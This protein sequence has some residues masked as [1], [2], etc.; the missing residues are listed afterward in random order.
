M[1]MVYA[2]ATSFVVSAS[3]PS[4]IYQTIHDETFE[5][6]QGALHAETVYWS[7]HAESGVSTVNVIDGNKSLNYVFDAS[8]GTFVTLGGTSVNAIVLKD[9]LYRVS[10]ELKGDGV[11][12]FSVKIEQS[13][14]WDAYHSF[15][16]NPKTGNR[17]DDDGL[18]INLS[19]DESLS[20][21][22][23]T[24]VSSLSFVFKAR[25]THP[26]YIIFD[27]KVS[28]SDPL[29]VIDNVKIE[30]YT[31]SLDFKTTVVDHF[32]NASGEIHLNSVFFLN[33]DEGTTGSFEDT[34]GIAIEN[35]SL[36]FGIQK[37]GWDIL[38][39]TQGS[40][41]SIEGGHTY[42]VSFDL[43][44][45][46][47]SHFVVKAKKIADD[48]NIYEMYVN[49]QGQRLP[50]SIPITNV[51]T[52]TVSDSIIHVSF[53]FS[54]LISDGIYLFFEA[55]SQ[56]VGGIVAI[57]HFVVREEIVNLEQHSY[58]IFHE[59]TFEGVPSETDPLVHFGLT[60]GSTAKPYALTESTALRG[61][62]SLVYDEL[63]RFQWNELVKTD[64]VALR[65]NA[66]KFHMKAVFDGIL[67]VKMSLTDAHG[68]IIHEL[69]FNAVTLKRTQT[70]GKAY[71][72]QGLLIENRGTL[73]I[74]Y[75]F[76]ELEDDLDHVWTLSVYP[77]VSDARVIIDDITFLVRKDA[78]LIDETLPAIPGLPEN[79]SDPIPTGKD[80]AYMIGS[81][82][83]GSST[84][85]LVVISSVSVMS[86]A[87]GVA[88]VWL[89]IKKVTIIAKKA[90]FASLIGLASLGL[91]FGTFFGCAKFDQSVEDVLD[92]A[93]PNISNYQYVYPEKL[94]GNLNN[95]GMGWVTLEEP[96]YGGHP[97]MGTSGPLPEVSNVSLSTSWAR[98]EVEEGVY[99]WTLMDQ[100]IDYYVVRGKR[101]NFRI[102][103]DS[104]MLP[105]T[106]SGTPQW[107]FDKY[108]VAY[109]IHNYTIQR[110]LSGPSESLIPETRTT[111]VICH[112]FWKLLQTNTKT[113][114]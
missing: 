26:S 103:T 77:Q 80:D 9:D 37:V 48:T 17:L 19:E 105:N 25:P 86:L 84:I 12:F 89:V 41:L 7:N 61:D 32:D 78:Q 24:G 20:Y 95:P 14:T 56:A 27:A 44:L 47:V 76:P 21:S 22:E 73:Y 29:I 65:N 28:D 96:T 54:S 31:E 101:I 106:Y 23:E 83:S 59:A 70:Y 67:N 39:G 91:A 34:P 88:G 97:D 15:H 94:S 92:D 6:V 66:F 111:N 3:P 107:L 40:E 30:K 8:I 52:V 51:E 74:D 112:F 85:A 55:Q 35:R 4:G 104:L 45:T 109:E 18:P 99:D 60:N 10:M 11:D 16:I 79:V 1:V 13:S 36:L 33:D 110:T 57:D 108:D 98:I 68:E 50:G 75:V 87:A 38:G 114:H 90:V 82:L 72:D 43:R 63:T 113:T 5:T 100:I 42:Q 71:M 2:L 46:N 58:G 53:E 102:V 69:F 62:Q 81:M 93:S 49:D 64:Q